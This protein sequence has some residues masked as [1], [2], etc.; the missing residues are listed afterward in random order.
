VKLY[1]IDRRTKL[2]FNFGNSVCTDVSDL[3]LSGLG[4]MQVRASMLLKFR[5]VLGLV[6]MLLFS[7]LNKNDLTNF[8]LKKCNTH[9]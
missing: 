8:A 3:D 9:Y 1:N 7:I 2:K 6:I 5:I 4:Q